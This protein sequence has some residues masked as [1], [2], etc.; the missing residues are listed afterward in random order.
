MSSYKIIVQGKEARAKLAQG[1]DKLASAVVSTYGPR[2]WNVA[3]NREYPGPKILHDGVSVARSIKLKDPFEDMGAA[4]IRDAASKTNDLAGDGTTTATLLANTLLQEGFKLVEG[5]VV[6][7]VISSQI[8]P[9][10][11]REELLSYSEQIIA[12]LDSKA[13]KITEKKDYQQIATISSG[14]QEIGE[15]VANAIEKVGKD[16]VVMVEE[17]PTF[18]STLDIHEGMEFDNGY[19]SSYFV[20]DSDRMITTYE[21]G[22]ILLTDYKIADA[23]QLVPIVE[24]VIKENNAPL[25]IIADDVVGPALQALVLTKIKTKANLVAVCAPEFA[26]RRREMLEDLAVLTGG[27]VISRDLDKKLEDVSLSD[28]GRFRSIRV[29][30]TTTSITPKNPDADDIK[31]RC[32]AIRTQIDAETN[33][34]KREKLQNRLAKLSSSVAIINVGGSSEGEISDK[35]ER[36]I[37]AIYATK[38]ALS[39]GIV[40]GGGVALRDIA[41]ELTKNLGKIGGKQPSSID[42]LVYHV[43]T[44]PIITIL[45]NGGLETPEEVLTWMEGQGMNVVTKG[46]VDM[47]EAGIIDPVKVTKL[48]VRNAFSVAA[49]ALTNN[50]LI[51]DD[52]EEDSKVQM[53]HAV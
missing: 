24:K 43:L 35:K 40:P 3:I 32:D 36:V 14:S 15:M 13:K 26:D 22:Y 8:N 31:E 47:I 46:S 38:A 39:E 50:F 28:L 48:A 41:N 9:M 11:L 18:E 30:Q 27:V 21:N 45:E 37:D 20:T 42:Q 49:T 7:G 5:G 53:V 34:F 33:D 23:M 16:G 52:P 1:A 10:V 6:D 44:T 19:L 17:S 4:L 2:S 29:T 12:L 51:S 25:L